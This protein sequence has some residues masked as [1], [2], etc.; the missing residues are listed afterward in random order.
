MVFVAGPRQVGKTTLALAL[1]DARRG[2][3]N[4]DVAEHR[5]HI[6]RRG[7][8]PRGLRSWNDCTPSSACLRLVHRQPVL[9]VECKGSDAATDKSLRYFKVRFPDCAAWQIS[10]TG[11]RDCVDADDIR[12][13]PALTLLSTLV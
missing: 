9:C 10:A 2:Y 4:W 11:T 8:P 1:P 5:A 3:L 12:V 7:L 6:L 13:A